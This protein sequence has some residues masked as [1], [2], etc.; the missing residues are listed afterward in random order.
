M[1]VM[2]LHFPQNLFSSGDCEF[3]PWQCKGHPCPGVQENTTSHWFVDLTELVV[4]ILIQVCRAV[5]SHCITDSLKNDTLALS[6][7]A[8]QYRMNCGVFAR[9]L[10]RK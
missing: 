2:N 8:W 7:P 3:S 1:K 9:K 5:Q 4:S 6:L 10:G